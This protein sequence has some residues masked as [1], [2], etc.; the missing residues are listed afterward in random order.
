M[1]ADKKFAASEDNKF[2]PQFFSWLGAG[3][4]RIEADIG[5]SFYEYVKLAEIRTRSS[6]LGKAPDGAMSKKG[7]IPYM[8]VC[9]PSRKVK[10]QYMQFDDESSIIVHLSIVGGGLTTQ[11][12]YI[13][14][15]WEGKAISDFRNHPEKLA[16]TDVTKDI[17]GLLR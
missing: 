16:V 7:A 4:R 13:Q 10:N 17:R 5:K 6:E 11:N 9:L 15:V 12:K 14:I 2:R 8:V 3:E 1:G